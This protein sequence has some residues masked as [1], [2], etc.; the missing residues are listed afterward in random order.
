MRKLACNPT[1]HPSRPTGNDGD[2]ARKSTHV[3]EDYDAFPSSRRYP[4]LSSREVGNG[5]RS[6]L[7]REDLRLRL[8]GWFR[9]NVNMSEVGANTSGQQW[10]LT[11]GVRPMTSVGC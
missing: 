4:R 1:T 5:G 11:P 9:H 7:R 3:S 6:I 8:A 2:S 10:S